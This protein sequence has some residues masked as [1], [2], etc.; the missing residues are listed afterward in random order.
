M[1]NNEI[2]YEEN[3]IIS[4]DIK[5]E[6]YGFSWHFDKSIEPGLSHLSISYG[7]MQIIDLMRIIRDAGI[8]EK[9]IF[10]GM[11]EIVTRNIIWKIFSAIKRLCPSFVQYYRLPSHK[12]HGVITRVE[13]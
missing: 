9:T 12:V 6:P 5:D 7:Y 4:L 10:Y 1:F 13:L 8:E 11:E 3:V 2:I